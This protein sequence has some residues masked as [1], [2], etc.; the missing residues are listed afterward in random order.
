MR[1]NIREGY[2]GLRPEVANRAEPRVSQT[3]L[4]TRHSKNAP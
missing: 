4:G 3:T 1:V 2:K